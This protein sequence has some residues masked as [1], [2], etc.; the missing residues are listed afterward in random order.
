MKEITIQSQYRRGALDEADCE[1]NPIAQFAKWF[2]DAQAAHLK[3]PNSMSVAT[4]GADGRPSLRI[5]LLKEFEEAGF[6]FYTNYG[7]RKGRDYETNRWTALTFFWAE[8]ERQVRV[9]GTVSK[10]SPEKSEEY[11]RN[12]PRGSRLGAW[13][14]NQSESIENRAV[15]EKRLADIEARYEGSDDI[16]PPPYW[17]GYLV[18]PERIEFWQGRPDRLHDRILY[19]KDGDSWRMGR[20][21]P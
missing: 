11:F 6:I 18:S 17:G 1:T 20:L 5:V 4:V 9:E 13:V 12:R 7:S 14:S 3:E 15:L 16:P 2:K 10:V 19:T 21:S 8:L